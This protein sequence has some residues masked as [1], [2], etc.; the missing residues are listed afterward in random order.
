MKSLIPV[1]LFAAFGLF[2]QTAAAQGLGLQVT[3]DGVALATQ[4]ADGGQFEFMA[5]GPVSRV[6]PGGMVMKAIGKDGSGFVFDS[7]GV[8]QPESHGDVGEPLPPQQAP[9]PT[10]KGRHKPALRTERAHEPRSEQRE[11]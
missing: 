11:A 10:T 2:P 8:V 5:I 3:R 7:R 6:R 1:I 4:G 9:V